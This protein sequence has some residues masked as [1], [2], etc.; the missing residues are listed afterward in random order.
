MNR[1]AETFLSSTVCGVVGLGVGA[2]TGYTIDL[3]DTF[4]PQEEQAVIDE[5]KTDLGYYQA[6]N[7]QLQEYGTVCLDLLHYYEDDAALDDR[8]EDEMVSDLLS[9][10]DQPCGNN[11]TEVRATSRDALPVFNKLNELNNKDV[12]AMYAALKEEVQKFEDDKRQDIWLFGG[13]IGGIAGILLGG[14][15]GFIDSTESAKKQKGNEN[16]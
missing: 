9:H 15:M 16:E 6:Y 10:P 5:Y 8:G 2:A 14:A 7:T 4:V 13:I 3:F 11:A 1:L 12:N